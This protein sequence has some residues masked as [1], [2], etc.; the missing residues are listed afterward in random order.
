M[1]IVE[2]S[3]EAFASFVQEAIAD[4]TG[5]HLHLH[6]IPPYEDLIEFGVTEEITLGE[7]HQR[8][9]SNPNMKACVEIFRK[10]RLE[11]GYVRYKILI[12]KPGGAWIY[13]FDLNDWVQRGL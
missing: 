13:A 5:S 3:V 1:T 7:F 8:F 12:R 2:V 4:P 6:R 10:D 9:L 11:R